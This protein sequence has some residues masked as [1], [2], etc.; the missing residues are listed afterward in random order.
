[1]KIVLLSPIG[2]AFADRVRAV[3]PDADVVA[4]PDEAASVAAVANAE[5][6]LGN[7]PAP[8]VFRAATQ[9]RWFQTESAGVNALLDIPELRDGDFIL[10]NGS[11][12]HRTQVA[13][14]AWAL[15]LALFKQLPSYARAQRARLWDRDGPRPRD[16]DGATA[17]IVGLGG[18]G[19][20]YAKRGAAF[21]MRVLAAD[22]QR[23]SK[24]EFV[25]ALWGMDRLDD[26][27]KAAD[28]LFL[29]CP[30]TP[31]TDRLIDARAFRLMKATAFLVNTARG[32]IVDEAA[33]VTALKE[34]EIAGAGLDVF[35]EE[36]LPEESPLWEMENVILL[37][38]MGGASAYRSGR[39]IDL[40]CEN[41]KRYLAGSPLLNEVDRELGYPRAEHRMGY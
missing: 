7:T 29:A 11:G 23:P 10:T 37:P 20:Q 24:P 39:V 13:E 15:T 4:P 31:A 2:Q 18:I 16:L 5:V 19:R 41:L 22:V 25:A 28:V 33:L 30:H 38:H 17:G 26:V 8:A 40:F 3:A 9:L 34:G 27:L 21:G 12:L 1:M 35:E 32:R 6:I 14:L 36:P